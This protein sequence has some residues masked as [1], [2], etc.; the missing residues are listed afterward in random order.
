M[1][2][3]RPVAKTFISWNVNG[4][5]AAEKKGFLR[6]LAES[7]ADVVGIQEV[8][9]DD[10]T[11]LNPELVT[12]KGYHSFWD[13]E[14]EKKGYS[15]VG[16]YTKEKPKKITKDFGD[17]P[18]SGYASVLTREGR[19]IEL[20]FG[21]FVYQNIYFP[22]GGSGEERLN[23]K[24]K[25]YQEFLAYN[26]SLL[27]AGKK[28]I[29]GGDVNTAHFPIDLARPKENEKK[30]GFMPIEREWLDK[31]VAAG[32]ID[33]F[34]LL[35]PEKVQYS[36]WDQKTHARDRNVGWRID[37]FWVSENLKGAVR[38][39]FIWDEV[40]GSDHAPVGVTLEV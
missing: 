19:M 27:R 22:N 12:P 34:R 36:W 25:F 23:Y 5:R 20:D 4:I 6:W 33:T 35:H 14:T 2:Y 24:L 9:I 1:C 29:F 10:E 16:V 40:M 18:L 38:K 37:Q 28:I 8:K 7:G 31:F 30:S 17:N 15:G 26:Q 13:L 32:F 39:A 3:N 21:D 11:K